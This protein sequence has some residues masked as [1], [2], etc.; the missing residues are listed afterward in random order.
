METKRKLTSD[1]EVNEDVSQFFIRDRFPFALC[2]QYPPVQR[3]AKAHQ[4]SHQIN[5]RIHSNLL[6]RSL[7][8]SSFILALNKYHDMTYM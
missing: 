8:Q 7:F 2:F 6:I 4:L 3:K 5:S 1:Q